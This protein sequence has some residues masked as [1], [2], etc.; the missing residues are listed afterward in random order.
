MNNIGT[1]KSVIVS[2]NLNRNLVYKLCPNTEFSEGAWNINIKTIAYSCLIPNFK[3]LCEISCN[4]V[5]SQRYNDSF[6]VESYDQ[7]FTIFVLES[8]K[9]TLNLGRTLFINVVEKI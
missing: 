1:I 7:P 6:E 2:G 4:L 8:Q 3:E 9:T 5:K